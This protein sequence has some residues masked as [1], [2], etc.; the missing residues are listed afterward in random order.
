[1]MLIVKTGKNICFPRNFSFYFY[2][3]QTFDFLKVI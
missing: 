3:E 2:N 1:M